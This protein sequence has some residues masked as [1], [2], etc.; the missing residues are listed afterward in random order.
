M[1]SKKSLPT[2]SKTQYRG[3]TRVL[4][5]KGNRSKY[6]VQ[7][8]FSDGGIKRHPKVYGFMSAEQASRAFDILGLKRYLE[9]STCGS[10][11]EAAEIL[12]LGQGRLAHTNHREGEYAADDRLME[13]ISFSSRDQLVYALKEVSRRRSVFSKESMLDDLCAAMVLVDPL[14]KDLVARVCPDAYRRII[15]ELELRHVSSVWGIRDGMGADL[16]AP[17]IS[18]EVQDV[19][20]SAGQGDVENGTRRKNNAGAHSRKRTRGDGSIE[21]VSHED[22]EEEEEEKAKKKKTKKR[23]IKEKASV[24]AA[25]KDGGGDMDGLRLVF[26]ICRLCGASYP[27]LHC[28]ADILYLWDKQH[29]LESRGIDGAGDTLH[30]PAYLYLNILNDMKEIPDLRKAMGYIWNSWSQGS[31]KKIWTHTVSPSG[32]LDLKQK[33]KSSPSEMELA[34]LHSQNFGNHASFAAIRNLHDSPAAQHGDMVQSLMPGA[35]YGPMPSW[36]I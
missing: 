4:N 13:L 8:V 28:C 10:W 26:D 19:G 17:R 20:P 25:R 24:E 12:K 7:F 6:D 36:N 15:K 18:Y 29:A 14:C 16:S 34:S 35:Q 2:R 31:L 23:K 21:H 27:E 3:V 22:E 32:I 30:Y 9:K 33:T 5:A 1:T 11:R